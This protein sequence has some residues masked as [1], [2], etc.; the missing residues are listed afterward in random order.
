MDARWRIVIGADGATE[1]LVEGDVDMAVEDA[2]HTALTECIHDEAARGR[3]LG[4]DL[5]RVG[6]M[7][8]AGLRSLMRLHLDHAGAIAINKVS[9]PVA[10][11]FE[12]AGVA[13]WLLPDRSGSSPETGVG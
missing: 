12:V 3:T 7:D 10:R 1:V 2:L 13:E 11:L 6:F 9:E 5:S 4:I 8:S